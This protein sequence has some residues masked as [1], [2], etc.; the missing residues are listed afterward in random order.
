[1]EIDDEPSAKRPRLGSKTNDMDHD[2]EPSMFTMTSLQSA[3][4]TI[5]TK[6]NII[7]IQQQNPHDLP[8]DSWAGVMGYLPFPDMLGLSAT[9]RYFSRDVS[10]LVRR[11]TIMSWT[12]ML[13]RKSVGRF[14]GIRHISIKV[15]ARG[16]RAFCCSR[17]SCCRA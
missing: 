11:L 15:G 5:G 13:T 10:P 1:M 8:V 3:L 12:Q 4:P 2:L 6:D 9:A 14:V 17:R 7:V 16:G